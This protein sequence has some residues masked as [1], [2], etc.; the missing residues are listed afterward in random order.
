MTKD[1]IFK[2]RVDADMARNIREL[3]RRFCMTPSQ[4]LR[5]LIEDASGG[6]DSAEQEGGNSG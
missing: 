1:F 4:L 6:V 2:A 3:C 5:R